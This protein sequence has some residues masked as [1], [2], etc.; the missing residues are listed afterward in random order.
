MAGS[1]ARK[2]VARVGVK[3]VPDTSE[4]G[5][6]LEA[7]LAK[8]A[9]KSLTIKVDADISEAEAKI[10]SL[11]RDRRIT[12]N[13]DADTAA[14]EEKINRAARDRNTKINL[15]VSSADLALLDR[16]TRREKKVIDIDLD[17]AQVEETLR[18]LELPSRKQLRVE[19]DA[20]QAR[21]ELEALTRP[22]EIEVR[23]E[24]AAAR[25]EIALLT[26]P[27]TKTINVDVDRV[28]LSNTAGAIG[29]F[30]DNIGDA[31]GRVG[32]ATGVVISFLAGL[33]QAA[34]LSFRTMALE[35]Y[36]AVGGLL[37]I[38]QAAVTATTMIL[39][40]G[41]VA[42]VIAGVVS[43]LGVLISSAGAAV[44]SLGSVVVAAAGLGVIPGI[45]AMVANQIIGQNKALKKAFGELS[46]QIDQS[47]ERAA[48]PMIAALYAAMN[49]LND[50]LR[51]GTPLFQELQK[52]FALSADALQP[53]VQGLMGLA[54]NVLV[55]VNDA[56]SNL[57]QADF[58]G[59]LGTG[60]III[61]DA[62]GK[63]VSQL[64]NWAP[65]IGNSF[66]AIAEGIRKMLP[67]F[68]DLMGAFSSFAPTVIDGVTDA[69]AKLFQAFANNRAVYETAA[70]AFAQALSDMAGPL[71]QVFAAF[72]KMAPDVMGALAAAVASFAETISDPQV[73]DGLT[74]LTT[75]LIDM[76]TAAVNAAAKI[77]DYVGDAANA[78]EEF[79]LDISGKI[80]QAKDVST[81]DLKALVS[82]ADSTAEKA[83]LLKRQLTATFGQTVRE[84]VR[85][86]R[87]MGKTWREEL[88]N[89][90]DAGNTAGEQLNRGFYERLLELTNT[91]KFEG[92]KVNQE[93]KQKLEQLIID[94][95][96]SGDQVAQ[97]MS[98]NLRKVLDAINNDGAKATET[99]R[100]FLLQMEDRTEA[101]K[102]AEILG[103]ELEHVNGRM[104]DGVSQAQQTF[105]SLPQ[106]MQT[107][108]NTAKTP[109]EMRAKLEAMN[110]VIEE[111]ATQGGKAFS[112]LPKEMEKSV[113]SSTMLK[114][115]MK[116]LMGDVKKEIDTGAAASMTAWRKFVKDLDTEVSSNTAIK[117]SISSLMND[118]TKSIGDGTNQSTTE[119]RKMF[120]QFEQLARS[121]KTPDVVGDNMTKVWQH[122][123]KR[124]GDSV[125]EFKTMS[126]DAAKYGQLLEFQNNLKAA[127]NASVS[128]VS[129]SVDRIISELQRLNSVTVAPKVVTP[130]G[131]GG[132]K[133][134]T[135]SQPQS[136]SGGPQ[137]FSLM[138]LPEPEPME[139]QPMV[140]A[141]RALPENTSAEALVAL[142]AGART[143]SEVASSSGGLGGATRVYDIDIHA[144]PN[145]PTEEQL[146]QQLSYADALYS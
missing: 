79:S 140:M 86:M 84:T 96:N 124:T 98:Q 36:Q 41:A 49:L 56:L 45:F 121:D 12:I 8:Y 90:A 111:G 2:E 110:K 142:A 104:A 87:E 62:I 78:I 64:S 134:G 37:G 6:K 67:P 82:E 51:V 108:I 133:A 35:A 128:S 97:R 123:D 101:L 44:L 93:W 40:I 19:L 106:A 14:A 76:T 114:E 54:Y 32:G 146:R 4:F 102:L 132:G 103:I 126:M 27:E 5:R 143:L 136:F 138:A 30:L 116:T 139:L 15:D 17:S 122:V 120:E 129:T 145:V 119:W 115:A 85:N 10:K 80:K 34:M 48:L 9:N 100:T 21:A 22:K 95:Q 52:A 71:E 18:R 46:D 81:Q 24:S 63:F 75:A 135:Q 31:L 130:S 25:A 113:K 65:E 47:I 13:V 11:L 127:M 3:V 33:G 83:E 141:A 144:A 69:F 118:I 53:L 72:A 70:N 66:L 58:F 29:G 43:A 99:W 50:S 60:F 74:K 42:S 92:N 20:A 26:R 7:E 68:A 117:T 39:K 109:E 107:I 91:I 73:I 88:E 125:N 55:G 1:P 137:L 131:G 89:M 16:L 57:L 94:T 77:G 23:V 112:K 105:S 61:G 28:S 59:K 38:A